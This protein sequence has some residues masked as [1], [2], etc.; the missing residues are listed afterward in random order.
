MI[1]PQQ[2]AI[3]EQ[4]VP[5]PELVD[6]RVHDILKLCETDTVPVLPVSSFIAQAGASNSQH[7]EIYK[8]LAAHAQEIARMSPISIVDDSRAQYPEEVAMLKEFRSDDLKDLSNDFKNIGVQ[9][10][11]EQLD[12]AP[13]VD[14]VL[15]TNPLSELTK[16][17]SDL[18]DLLY[19]Y[20][21]ELS[22]LWAGTRVLEE[23]QRL[24][25]LS[26]PK[27]VLPTRPTIAVYQF[28]DLWDKQN[29]SAGLFRSSNNEWQ[30]ITTVL[31]HS[32]GT[33]NDNVRDFQWIT[34]SESPVILG[35]GTSRAI[36]ASHEYGGHS[37]FYEL[38]SIPDLEKYMIATA[39]KGKSARL[40]LAATEGYAIHV[41]RIASAAAV[42]A[43]PAKDKE[44]AQTESTKFKKLRDDYLASN[45]NDPM[46]RIYTDGDLMMQN[47]IRDAGLSNLPP[48]VQLDRI[49]AIFRATDLVALAKTTPDNP[50]YQQCIDKPLQNLPRVK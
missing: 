31:D 17:T 27:Q 2:T 40:D 23:T 9:L 36:R 28:G 41:E 4:L 42:E 46:K 14:E 18:T 10:S 26:L 25:A 47:M 43:T 21:L 49:R 39:G 19:A 29:G 20:Q 48:A 32:H 7:A 16:Q 37:A 3:A 33:G 24:L 44:T 38:F 30:H 50:L 6:V 11:P 5:K 15:T 22:G 1:E 34:K 45:G 13:P 8:S 35:K 12:A